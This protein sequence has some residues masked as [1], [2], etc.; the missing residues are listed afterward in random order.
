M[1]CFEVSDVG[2]ESIADCFCR[3]MDVRDLLFQPTSNDLTA[4]CVSAISSGTVTDDQTW[5]LGGERAPT[6]LI[7]KRVA[8][9]FPDAFLKNVYMTTS[10]DAKTVQLSA[11]TDSPSSSSFG[12]TSSASTIQ[13]LK[14]QTLKQ[15]GSAARRHQ[16][17]SKLVMTTAGGLA[18]YFAKML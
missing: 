16:K 13:A 17:R 10:V 3:R 9:C 7:L 14:D 11:R 4:Q 15:S 12:T 2:D 8:D 18:A 6:P 5:L 1:S